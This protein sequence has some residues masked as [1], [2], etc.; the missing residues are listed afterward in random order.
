MYV[1]IEEVALADKYSC[2]FYLVGWVL[3]VGLRNIHT[4]S[5]WGEEGRRDVIIGKIDTGL[6]W[7][8]CLAGRT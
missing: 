3:E 8:T 2:I 7:Y 1:R 4:V 6:H 5:I